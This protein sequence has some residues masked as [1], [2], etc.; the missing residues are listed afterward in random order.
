DVLELF[1]T[2]PLIGAAE[3][4]RI[5]GVP[6]AS[7]HRMLVSLTEAGALEPTAR[8]QYR[9]TLKM[10]E[11]GQHVPFQRWLFDAAYLPMEALVS[12][13]R[14]ASHFAVRDRMDLV[15]IV[16]LRHWPDRT[17][18]RPGQR[19]SL[20]ATALG[21]VLLAHAP[22]EIVDERIS[23]GLYRFTQ[24]TIATRERLLEQLETI[25]SQGFAYDREERTIGLVSIAAPIR[26]RRGQVL[27]SLSLLGPVERYRQS[28]DQLR[29]DLTVTQQEIEASLVPQRPSPA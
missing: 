12:R 27:A 22:S 14:L 13:T 17:R 1:V 6:R 2:R 19:N 7:A 28:L 25:R 4:A 5:L 18:A 26:G 24:Y 10:F 23:Q 9:L 8:G 20:H 3:C 21:K 15:Y 11:L 16:K 29:G